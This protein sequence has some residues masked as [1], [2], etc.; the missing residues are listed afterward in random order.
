MHL[1]LRR[2]KKAQKIFK[3]KTKKLYMRRSLSFVNEKN[4]HAK[5]IGCISE[6]QIITL[7]IHVH[8][9][10]MRIPVNLSDF[11]FKSQ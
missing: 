2:K 9:T 6:L 8:Y 4:N 5:E 1:T 3:K 11:F 7:P 10:I